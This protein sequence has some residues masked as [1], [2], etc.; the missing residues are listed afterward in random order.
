MSL[1][2][3]EDNGSQKMVSV[4]AELTRRQNFTRCPNKSASGK[5]SIYLV[6]EKRN[7]A[8]WSE[9]GCYYHQIIISRAFT[10]SEQLQILSIK[11]LSVFDVNL[12][13]SSYFLYLKIL[14]MSLSTSYLVSSINL[15]SIPY[16]C[17]SCMY[18]SFRLL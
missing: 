14:P 18:N 2:V 4:L 10:N 12:F 5:H 17:N 1:N 13:M 11:G 9:R 16:F 8:I 15:H 3:S 7:H 6:S